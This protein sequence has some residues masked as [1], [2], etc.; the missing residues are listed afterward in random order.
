MAA[1]IAIY[2]IANHK[3]SRIVCEAMA[4]GIAATGDKVVVRPASSWRRK[5]ARIA[6]FYG[7][8][9]NLALALRQQKLDGGTAIYIDLGWWGRR[10]G[11]RWGCYHK[12]TI[13]DRHPTAYFQ[14]RAHDASR[15]AV[16][17]LKIAPWRGKGRHILVAGMSA[18]AA[19]AEGF[20]PEQ[21]E[22]RTIAE[23]RR[24]TARP[25]IYRAKPNWKQAKPLPGAAF[26]PGFQ[27]LD[28]ALANCHAVVGHHSNVC[29][30]A[31]IAGV[32]VFCTKGVARPMGL[33]DLKQI[34]A[35]ILPDD[36]AQWAADVA[37]CQWDVREMAEG[38]PWRHLKDE[39]LIP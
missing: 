3:R 8:V 34:E 35:P 25:I 2:Q 31:L 29:V 24:F 12:I 26:S 23:L 22:R 37:W 10:N 27:P 15:F 20:A 30:D 33:A 19:R 39:G 38:L 36:R 11:G 21:W 16:H 4:R 32:P 17:K 28:K 5:Q 6:V 14:N 9:G 13:D 7:L 18:K 1:D